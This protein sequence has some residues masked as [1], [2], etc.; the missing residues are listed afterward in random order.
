MRVL[1]LVS[2]LA[3]AM[4]C[5]GVIA[6][7]YSSLKLASFRRRIVPLTGGILICVAVFWVL[8]DLVEYC[9]WLVSLSAVLASLLAL[10]VLNHFVY[11][12][13][14][15]CL[16]T[17]AHTSPFPAALIV[18]VGIHSFFDGWSL[19][20]SGDHDLGE[21]GRAISWGIAV[22]KLPEGLVL[23]IILRSLIK[24]RNLALASALG[25]NVV[26]LAGGILQ[27]SV[28]HVLPMPWLIGSL[29]ISAASFLF[30]GF[31][32]LHDEWKHRGTDGTLH[33]S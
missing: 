23:G 9:G 1:V 26:F 28:S 2:L 22:H 27:H 24:S 11:P 16:G 25:A 12:V 21:L 5:A 10:G 6:A 7:D 29:S 19:T 20:L 18:A 30:L 33:P 4:S 32:V 3:F 13:C 17:H 31:N 14:P 15:T 8:P